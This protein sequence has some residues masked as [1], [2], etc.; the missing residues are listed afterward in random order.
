MYKGEEVKILGVG[1]ILE[2]DGKVLMIEESLSHTEIGKSSNMLAYPLETVKSN[3]SVSN[4]AERG[5][6]EEV[7]LSIQV[8]HIVGFYQFKG[9][10]GVSFAGSL[11]DQGEININE[12]EINKYTWL[13]KDEIL[14]YPNLRPGVRESITDYFAGQQYP[15]EIITSVTK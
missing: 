6:L 9:G 10:F 4:A 14:A 11:L 8:K 7:G 13:S 5:F 3:E 15:L 12:E 2:K 1:T